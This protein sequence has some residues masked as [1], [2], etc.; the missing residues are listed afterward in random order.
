MVVDE[1][2]EIKNVRKAIESYV[3]CEDEQKDYDWYRDLIRDIFK[4]KFD[5]WA[6]ICDSDGDEYPDSRYWGDLYVKLHI[7]D[8][9]DMGLFRQAE[10][11]CVSAILAQR[12]LYFEINRR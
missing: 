7:Y 5:C 4:I 9:V 12:H 11:M 10:D 3:D 8:D 1:I 6:Q 2:I